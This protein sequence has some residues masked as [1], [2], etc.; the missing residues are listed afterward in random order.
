MTCNPHRTLFL[1]LLILRM[2]LPFCI[3]VP[4]F[5]QVKKQSNAFEMVSQELQLIEKGL[6]QL[7]VGKP[8]ARKGLVENPIIPNVPPREHQSIPQKPQKSTQADA[9]RGAVQELQ[10][11]ES[12]LLNLHRE[13]RRK[14]SEATRM[15]G[16][17]IPRGKLTRLRPLGSYFLFFNPGIT[18]S[19]E[20]DYT[21]STGENAVLGTDT[22]LDIAISFGR[23]IGP[24]A[25]GAQVSH[26]RFS[27]TQLTL[28]TET[29]DASGDSTSFSFSLYGGHDL[30]I[31]NS[32]NLH[33]GISLGLAKSDEAFSL[34]GIGS[35]APEDGSHFQGGLGIAV[36]YAF[37]DLCAAH[38]G[39]RFTYVGEVGNFASLPI[40]QVELGLRWN[41]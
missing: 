7:K 6:L 13:E 34:T 3:F 2:V 12:N 29:Y 18:F 40:N 8:E 10:P 39:Y 20:R 4:T 38:L 14:P 16:N 9:I 11:V 30:A 17:T 41:L 28:A 36:E 35:A 26:R 33:A 25:L 24:W 27:Y 23:Q 22:G 37:S 15:P 5:G 19:R 21:L 32:W 1:F 31:A